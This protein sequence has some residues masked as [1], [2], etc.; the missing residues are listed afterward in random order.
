MQK[1][2][3]QDFE[4]RPFGIL[5]HRRPPLE[6]VVTNEY[7]GSMILLEKKGLLMSVTSYTFYSCR[8][9]LS[10]KKLQWQP[11]SQPVFACLRLPA[12]AC[13]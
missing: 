10:T 4:I 6:Q 2:R 5:R 1:A 3:F 11:F 9:L 8:R 7:F 13:R 12:P